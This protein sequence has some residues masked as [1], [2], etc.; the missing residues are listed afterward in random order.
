TAGS[1]DVLTGI[2]ASACSQGLDVDEAAVYSTYLHAE[3]VHQYCQYI[4]EQGL[5]ASD[6]I[7]MLPYA[8]EELHNVY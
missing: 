7:K 3:C 2:L 8:Q 1:G 5:I 4:S 6:I